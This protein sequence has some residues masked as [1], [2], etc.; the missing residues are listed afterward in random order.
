MQ[1]VGHISRIRPDDRRYSTLSNPSPTAEPPRSIPCLDG[2]RAISILLVIYEHFYRLGYRNRAVV[3]ALEWIPFTGTTGVVLFF[4]I[5]GFLITTLLLRERTKKGGISF[6]NFY[7]RRCLRIFP[8]FYFYLVCIGIGTL[9]GWFSATPKAFVFSALYL[10]NLYPGNDSTIIGHTWSLSIEEQFYLLWPFAIAVFTPRTSLALAVL[11]ITAWPALRF[12]KKGYLFSP[13]PRTAL[14]T[15]ALDTILFGCLL[16]FIYND[17]SLR[18]KFSGWT[19][20]SWLLVACCI[21]LTLDYTCFS[22]IPSSLTF[23]CP[24]GRN[25]ALTGILWWAVENAN[26]PIGKILQ[27]APLVFIGVQSYSLYLWQQPFF[28]RDSWLCQPPQNVLATFLCAYLSY[29]FIERALMGLRSR[30]R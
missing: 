20:G 15:A 3:P 2:L 14:D 10:F 23:L 26:H 25:L 30:F 5:S 24:W 16:A 9:L 17:D 13:D 28:G 21:V 1:E 6:K 12:L 18:R 27:S 22:S 7:I 19:H 4:I 8:P 11:G 29:R